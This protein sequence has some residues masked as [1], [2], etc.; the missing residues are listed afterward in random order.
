MT[1]TLTLTRPP[2]PQRLSLP[3]TLAVWVTVLATTVTIGI[4]TRPPE[5]VEPEAPVTRIEPAG[6][7]LPPRAA[8]PTRE[9]TGPP[10]HRA[11]AAP[12]T[13][14]AALLELPSPT[15]APPP[16]IVATATTGLT[17]PTTLRTST[18]LRTTPT[19]PTT[20]TTTTTTTPLSEPE[21]PPEPPLDDSG[22]VSDP[23][24]TDGPPCSVD[25]PEVEVTP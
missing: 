7:T 5:P 13:P 18:T 17:T 3:A 6:P 2:R 22:G 21:S 10:A 9:A 20:A 24:V 14:T 4:A 11:T 16:S 1:D 19:T 25:C 23:P 12:A 8:S 15:T